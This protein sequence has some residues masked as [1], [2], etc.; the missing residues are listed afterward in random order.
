MDE[1][2]HIVEVKPEPKSRTT[3]RYEIK[4]YRII[5]HVIVKGYENQPKQYAYSIY[6]NHAKSF[7]EE[8]TVRGLSFEFLKEQTHRLNTDY[9]LYNRLVNEYCKEMKQ[10]S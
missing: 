8:F 10:I 3:E 7:V 6:D 5:K 2:N 9:H 1:W 4:Q